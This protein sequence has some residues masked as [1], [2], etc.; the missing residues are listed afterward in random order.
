MLKGDLM[1]CDN[2][3][4]MYF[5]DRLGDTY[6]WRGENVATVEVENVMSSLLGTVEVAVYGVEVPREEGKAGMA[7]II[8]DHKQM[9]TFNPEKLS[10]ELRA[11][12]PAYARPVFLRLTPKVEHTGNFLNMIN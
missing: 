4:Y 10:D 6:R 11:H 2:Y 7:A 8:L 5:C 9:S 3:G 12:L 1:A